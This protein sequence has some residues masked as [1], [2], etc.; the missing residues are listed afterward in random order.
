MNM[1]ILELIR[2]RRKYEVRVLYEA[3]TRYVPKHVLV[4]DVFAKKQYELLTKEIEI[5]SQTIG[6]QAKTKIR[7]ECKE[8]GIAAP[9]FKNEV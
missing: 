9:N 7:K 5:L 4:Y 6:G 2:E 8:R 1:T 3:E